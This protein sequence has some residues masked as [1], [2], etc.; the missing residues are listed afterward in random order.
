LYA[1]GD[2]VGESKKMYEKI[3]TEH[4]TSMYLPIAQS[5]IDEIK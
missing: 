4:E 2:K 5:K 3:V 1:T